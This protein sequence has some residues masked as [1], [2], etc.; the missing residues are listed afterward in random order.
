MIRLLEI[1]STMKKSDIEIVKELAQKV[2]EEGGR[3]LLK[4]STVRE[5]LLKVPVTKYICAAYGLSSKK[6]KHIRYILKEELEYFNGGVYPAP[7]TYEDTCGKQDFTI[8]AVLKDP[9]TEEYIDP[10]LGIQDIDLRTLRLVDKEH[11]KEF[12]LS[13][14]ELVRLSSTLNFEIEDSTY[15]LAKDANLS[16][17]NKSLVWQ[18]V[19]D[20]LLNSEFPSVG[21]LD[22]YNLSVL[23]KV[24]DFQPYFLIEG[25]CNGLDYVK[26]VRNITEE[27]RIILLVSCLASVNYERERQKTLTNLGVPDRIKEQVNTILR[28]YMSFTS[29][30]ATSE[31]HRSDEALKAISEKASLRLVLIFVRGMYGETDILKEI[32]TRARILG[33]YG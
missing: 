12:P 19:S 22:M 21:F 20:L 14:I 1:E 24:L 25:I 6:L 7:G 16:D 23:R 2:A 17:L 30:Y 9:L 4:G 31:L 28:N 27:E 3:L 29:S 33:I 11:F 10:F 26:A 5:E 18:K 13:V 32:E 15:N 8:N